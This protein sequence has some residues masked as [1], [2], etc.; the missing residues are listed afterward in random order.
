MSTRNT[1]SAG[2]PAPWFRQRS[3]AN[4]DYSFD[5]A[6]GRYIVLC[7]FGSAD[8]PHSRAAIEA[9]RS[10]P[11]IFDDDFVSFFGVSADPADETEERIANSYPGYRYF[12]DFDGKIGRAYGAFPKDGEAL[13]PRAAERSWFVLDPTLRIMLVLPFKD[14]QSDVGELLAFL[15]RLSPPE[16]FAGFEVQAPIL[17]LPQVFEPDFCRRLIDLYNEDGGRESGF[18]LERDGK[19]VGEM[20]HSHKRR[21]DY[22]ISDQG[23]IEEVQTRMLRRVVPEILKVHQFQVT[24]MER[25]LVGCYSAEDGGHFAPH[26]DNTT[27]GTA[28]RRFAVSINLNDDFEGGEVGFPEY[29]QRRYK[30]PVGGA[31]VFS[32]SLLHSVSQVTR[33]SRY[34]FLPF[35]YDEAAAKIREA[36]S[37]FIV[38][39]VRK[40]QRDKKG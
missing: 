6:A 3:F 11:A 5:I 31:V 40:V 13:E 28:H 22:H 39:G 20:D 9:A 29:G 34:A 12:W 7:Y 14:D 32:C 18:M 30:A 15:D 1:L 25:Y 36:N 37:Q 4:P 27:S 16:A 2:E 19:T 24:R 17:I 8:D 10:R 38:E 33:G 21:R 26:R 23:L 35:L